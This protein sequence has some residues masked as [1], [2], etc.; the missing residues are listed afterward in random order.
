[1][2]ARLDR[3]HTEATEI[4][5]NRNAFTLI[6]LLIVVAIIGILAAIAVP[7]FLNAQTRAKLSRCMADMRSLSLG[8]E[9]LKLDTSHL[10]IDGWDD[11]TTE[12]RDI[13]KNIFGGVGDFSEA[14]RKLS[15]YF[16]VLTSPIAYLSTIP[17]D[18]F[19]SLAT[20]EQNRGTGSP[21]DTYVYADVDPRIPGRNQGIAALNSPTAER[22]GLKPL[23][24][25]EYAIVGTG[26]DG[27]VG[28]RTERGV[29]YD[30]SNGLVSAGDIFFRS[31]GAFNR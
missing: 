6:E 14:E 26:P 2:A 25:G 9:Q 10:P 18:P 3:K 15:V 7:N 19:L 30:S 12:G 31:G 16:Y 4:M 13:L 28:G 22:F 27:I 8:I 17:I 20:T 29:P 1:M 23:E 24:V 11:D 5:S 21:L